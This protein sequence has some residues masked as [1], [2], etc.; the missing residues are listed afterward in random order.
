M[1]TEGNRAAVAQIVRLLDGLPLAI[2][3]AA[4]RIRIFSPAQLVERMRNR[5]ALLAGAR[6]A[7]ARQATLQGAIDWSWELLAAWEQAAFAQ[8][9]VFDGGFTL[10]AAEAVLDLSPWP[11]APPAMD[12]IQALADKSLLRTWI[13]A[14][15]SRY[16]IDEP[17][18]GMYL[19]IREYAANKLEAS[20]S[21]KKRTTE[22]RHGRYF[23]GFGGDDALEG[24]AREGGVKRRLVLALELD[25]LVAACRRAAMRNDAGVAV[26][27]YRA[28][29]EVF[30]LHGPFA[31][32]IALGEQVLSLE[33]L[34][35]AQRTSM[36][37]M[38]V[39]GSIGLLAPAGTANEII[40]KIAQAT[41]TAIAEPAYQRML[42]DAGIEPTLESNPEEFRRS[43]AAD[44]ALW[45][46]VVK[47]LGLKID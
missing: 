45:T 13:P 25:N 43:L 35:D 12:V 21:P 6:G 9:A 33:D 34:S 3:L 1:L 39:R 42:I 46:P 23:A 8:C 16:D 26:A 15:Q 31:A 10:E 29:A 7:A 44:V 38:T 14:T 37:A 32:D 2:E 22:E 40:E 47:A 17:F 27:T 19:S 28:S 18:F 4:A 30:A 41:R 20:G 11:E 24:L 36:L 5:F